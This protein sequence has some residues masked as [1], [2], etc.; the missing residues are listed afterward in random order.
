MQI[1]ALKSVQITNPKRRYS[2]AI[3]KKSVKKKIITDSAKIVQHNTSQIFTM[4]VINE[5]SKLTQKDVM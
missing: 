3:Q 2:S 5:A 4:K 1:A